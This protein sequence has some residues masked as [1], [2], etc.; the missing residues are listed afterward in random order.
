MVEKR[1]NSLIEIKKLKTYFGVREGLFGRVGR[2]VRAVDEVSFEI[3]AGRTLGLVGESGCGKS[4]LARTIL[5]LIPAAAGEVCFE[6]L[7]VFALGARRMRRLR[8]DMQIIFQDPYSSLNPRMTVGG[9]IGEGLKV[10]KLVPKRQRQQRIVELLNMVGLSSDCM[11][12]YPHEFSGGQRQRIG[13]AR[14]LAVEPKFIVCD[15]PVSG[16]D[17][18][19]QAKI[20][21]L[22]KDLQAKLGLTY[23]FISHDMNV[24]EHV[25]DCVAV[26]YLGRVVEFADRDSLFSGPLHPYTREL[27]S[28]ARRGRKTGGN[29]PS[30]LSGEVDSHPARYGGCAFHPRCALAEEK[31]RRQRP[32][33]A[34]RSG[35]PGHRAACW[36][37]V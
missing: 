11:Y 23:L 28:S 1:M 24:I 22:L 31:C 18:S 21:N 2:R 6:G 9:I 15:E 26:M 19:V 17:V 14:A 8:G 13:I 36:K 27:L 34:G 25:S 35:L 29:R 4:T 33:L 7:D 5:R 12:R 20:I 32:E 10:H 30:I 37:A 16:L 3:E